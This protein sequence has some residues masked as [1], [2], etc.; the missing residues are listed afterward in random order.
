MNDRKI[1]DLPVDW[2]MFERIT[3]GGG[4]LGNVKMQVGKTWVQNIK[5]VGGFWIANCEWEGTEWEKLDLFLD[6]LGKGIAAY[7][8][9]A[10]IWEGFL[11]EMKLTWSGQEYVVSWG[12][13]SNRVKCIYTHI[14]DNLLTNG[15][16]ESAA[17]AAVGTP[18]TREQSTVWV[19]DGIYSC[20][21]VT[22]AVDEGG[23]IQA[24]T[25]I[26]ASQSYVCRCSV[27]VVSGSWELVV[28]Q[29][30]GSATVLTS[31]KVATAGMVV[32]NCS[33]DES[34]TYAGNIGV[35]LICKDAAGEIYG[36]GAV[37]QEGPCRAETS[38]VEE[39]TSEDK[40]GVLE[41][42]LL[43]AGM[44]DA[45]ADALVLTYKNKHS[46]A[47]AKAPES[48]SPDS[49]GETKLEMTW[50]GYAW[51]LRS[52]YSLIAGTDAASDHVSALLAASEFVTAGIIETNSM[53]YQIDDQAPLT[54]W[55]I[56]GDIAENGDA[57]GNVWG[58]G[59]YAGRLA[60]YRAWDTTCLTR[61][62]NGFLYNLSGGEMEPWLM[63]P[64]LVYLDDMP[65]G[66]VGITGYT[67]DDPHVQMMDE[68]EWSVPEWLAGKS[69]LTMRNVSNEEE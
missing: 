26:V 49:E 61:F 56:L 63:Q 50:L 41:E 58:L 14:G 37:F 18:P 44:S 32:L 13:I 42:I 20:H 16:A 7:G 4:P 57:S 21:L 12:E 60:E 2:S 10:T 9:G 30:D 69:G 5:R 31:A 40:Y 28:Y 52:P 29:D 46:W 64:G 43:K 23:L 6:G 67:M 45:A 1:E 55:E 24:G 33:I 38:W 15:S 53:N 48:F 25:A 54:L 51:T 66:P 39:T 36:D 17:W 65:V 27:K 62:R 68:V 11:G 35:Q 19:S 3:E 47:H 34:N 22:N 59:I 8:S